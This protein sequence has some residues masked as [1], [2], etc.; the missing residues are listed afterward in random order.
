MGVHLNLSYLIQSAY[1]VDGTLRSQ[2]Y[3]R[4]GIQLQLTKHFNIR[5]LEHFSEAPFV[6]FWSP[7]LARS[8]VRWRNDMSHCNNSSPQ[9]YARNFT[10][11]IIV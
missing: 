11:Y 2:N 6:D 1:S 9:V 10:L 5:D 8:F 4:I 7:T 3:V